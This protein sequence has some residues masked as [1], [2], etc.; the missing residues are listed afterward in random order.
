MR[1]EPGNGMNEALAAAI[2]D[3]S[4]LGP[5]ANATLLR[6]WPRLVALHKTAVADVLARLQRGD[7]V[8]GLKLVRKAT[9]RRWRAGPSP[10]AIADSMIADGYLG[11]NARALL[12][13]L[14]TPA[15]AEALIPPPLR[16]RFNADYLDKPEGELTVA[17]AG[18]RR[19]NVR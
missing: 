8:A 5:D 10:D 7:K 12:F 4:P 3:G 17:P 9:R 2:V 6:L 11:H 19:R 18:D 1:T 14:I 16:E 13:A 15:Q